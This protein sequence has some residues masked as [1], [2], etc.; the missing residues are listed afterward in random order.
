MR[1]ELVDIYTAV[2]RLA[3]HFNIDL[4][5]AIAGLEDTW[6]RTKGA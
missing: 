6:L 5:K 4:A 1:S 3:D 2:I